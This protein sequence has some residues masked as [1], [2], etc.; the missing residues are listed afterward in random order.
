MKYTWGEIQILAIQKM[1]LNSDSIDTDD[2][3]T[4][5]TDRKYE[6]YLNSMPAVANEGLLRLMTVG[7]PLVKKYTLSYGVPNEV[8]SYQSYESFTVTDT[9]V[10]V[11]GDE[12]KAYYFELNNNAV[13]EIYKEATAGVW[14][15]VD[16]ITHVASVAGAY[17]SY[18]GLISNAS[19]YNIK[20]VFK[21]NGYVYTVRNVALYNVNFRTEEEVYINTRKQKYN[22]ETL[23]KDFFA[24]V[25]V[26]IETDT[27]K[28]DYSTDFILEGDNTLVI[29][30]NKQGNF[31]I[32]YKAYPTKLTVDTSDTYKFTMPADMVSLLPLYIASE[33]YKD[34]DASLSMQWRN[35]FEVSLSNLKSIEEPMSFSNNSN[36]M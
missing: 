15:L 35:Q 21:Q 33:L 17:E 4:M 20:L 2:L 5:R 31:I 22:L 3:E 27:E 18:K 30:S 7:K 10:E 19:L 34:D 25:S 1:F 9:D 29:D 12:A 14:T 24:I 11:E 36:W 32:T 28:G 6:L 8:Y 23:I 26:E 13:V 16:T